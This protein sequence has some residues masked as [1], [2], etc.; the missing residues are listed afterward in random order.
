MFCCTTVG[1]REANRNGYRC[2]KSN[3]LPDRL[4]N[5]SIEEADCSSPD[6][7]WLVKPPTIYLFQL[8]TSSILVWRQ[9]FLRLIV[10]ASNTTP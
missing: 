10:T 3:H 4:S 6:V 9:A 1:D 7:S 2:S 5:K 8:A